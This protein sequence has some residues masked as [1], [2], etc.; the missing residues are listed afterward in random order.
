MDLEA[1]SLHLEKDQMFRKIIQGTTIEPFSP[2]GKVYYDLL[3]S[4]VSQQ[5]SVK[6]AETIFQRFCALF[7]NQY[8]SPEAILGINPEQLRSAGLSNQKAGYMKNV[9][10]FALENNLETRPWSRYSDKENLDFLIQIKGIGRWSAEMI[11]MFTLGQPDVFPV[12]DLGIQQSISR[13]YALSESGKALRLR[14]IELAENWRPYRTVACRYLWAWKN[15][16]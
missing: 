5:L 13:L 4:I 7:P 16:N 12:D 2:S 15:N 3:N 8:P 6:A 9:A 11:L 1:A 10:A 14:M